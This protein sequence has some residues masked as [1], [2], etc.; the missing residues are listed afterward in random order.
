MCGN[1]WGIIRKYNLN[2]CRQCF[3][4]YAKDIGFVKVNALMRDILK[5]YTVEF[6]SASVWQ[7]LKY[8]SAALIFSAL[9]CFAV[10]VI[11]NYWVTLTGQLEE[12]CVDGVSAGFPR[13]VLTKQQHQHAVA[14]PSTSAADLTVQLGA[15]VDCCSVYKK[16][17]WDVSLCNLSQ[18][19]QS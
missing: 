10:P 15:V 13:N 9:L 4:E 1:K 2:I 17:S 16:A 5:I 7:L 8:F 3:R 18:S 14:K 19:T 11:P 6:V 12:N